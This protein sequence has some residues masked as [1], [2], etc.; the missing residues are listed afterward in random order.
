MTAVPGKASRN[1]SA[2][3]SILS[4]RLA[5]STIFPTLPA[6]CRANSSPKPDEAPVIITLLNMFSMC[7]AKLR[8]PYLQPSNMK[9]IVILWCERHADG[10][11]P[12]VSV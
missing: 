3:R 12:G 4:V 2:I 1:L 11:L 7:P 5:T 10:D 6:S 8:S 9:T